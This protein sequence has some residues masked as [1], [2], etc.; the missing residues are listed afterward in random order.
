VHGHKSTSQIE[1][2]LIKTHVVFSSQTSNFKY[3]VI[4]FI[5][6]KYKIR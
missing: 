2:S 3:F 5:N 1:S 6:N 4:L